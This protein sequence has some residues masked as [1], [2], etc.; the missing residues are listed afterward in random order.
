MGASESVLIA[1]AG[2]AAWLDRFRARFPEL[3]FAVARDP[4]ELDSLLPGAAPTVAYSCKT[5]AFPGPAHRPLLDVPS[6]RWLQ[7][8]GSGHDHLEGWREAGIVLTNAAGVLAPA[9]AEAAVGAML[10]LAFGLKRYVR[11]QEAR[12]WRKGTW[13]PL[14]GRTL[15]VVGAGAIG[16]EVAL[17]AKA[18]GLRVIALVRRPRDLPGLDDVRP[19][20]DL[21][22]SLPEADIVSLH[23]RLTSETTGL[24]DRP[25]LEA[26]RRGALFLNSARGGLV[27]EAALADLLRAGRIAGAW[28]DVT[29]T[30]PLPP[31]SPLWGLD[32]LLLTPHCADQVDGWEERLADFFMD[33]LE[34]HLAGRPLLNRVA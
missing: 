16:T 12:L 1:H 23:L 28:L 24:F 30:E 15:L 9:L 11:Q 4:A 10:A 5:D 27:D 2:A 8:G 13:R 25:T 22:R 21:H 18:L 6:L 19:L 14:A 3:P 34:R 26:V 32:N 17:R 33:N 31:E 29:A 20:S 7:V